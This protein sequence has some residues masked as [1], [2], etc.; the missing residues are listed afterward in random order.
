MVTFHEIRFG[1]IVLLETRPAWER[2][3]LLTSL[4]SP[5]VSSIDL[6]LGLKDG[7][8]SSAL[9]PQL[10]ESLRSLHS[11]IRVVI[12]ESFDQGIDSP[13]IAYIAERLSSPTS[14]L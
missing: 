9:P 8:R 3:P 1:V 12:T 6:W 4:L 10:F 14:N 2:P 11:D 5:T 7:I 13:E